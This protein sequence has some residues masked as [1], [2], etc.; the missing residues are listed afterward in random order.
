MSGPELEAILNNVI[1]PRVKDL[2]FSGGEIFTAKGLLNKALGYVKEKRK[3]L[4][5]SLRVIVQTN[6]FWA[7]DKD[8]AYAVLKGLY[9][10]GV[11]LVDLT[12]IDDYHKEQGLDVDRLESSDSCLDKALQKVNKGFLFG[13]SCDLKL[14]KRGADGGVMPF[15]R[16]KSLSNKH[17]QEYFTCML[18]KAYINR[19]ITINPHGDAYACCWEVPY[20]GS[21]LEST[22][23]ELIEK[24]A[25]NPI[26]HAL[27]EEGPKGVAK[28]IGVYNEGD[29]Y[30]NECVKCAELFGALK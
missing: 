23:D 1:T 16:A 19:C 26:L 20:L 2:A 3:K 12:S 10:L 24:A 9:G 7:K 30:R 21:A 22:A 15:G 14:G 6:G 28:E 4:S 18:G 8:S 11:N 13:S 25:K 5:P 27:M 29:S 17:H